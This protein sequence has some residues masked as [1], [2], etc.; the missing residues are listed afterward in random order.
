MSH[1]GEYRVPPV[2]VGPSQKRIVGISG[3]QG[4]PHGNSS[5]YTAMSAP[6]DGDTHM[7]ISEPNSRPVA[8]YIYPAGSQGVRL[9]NRTTPL[10]HHLDA[11]EQRMTQHI[12][13]LE[14]KIGELA[15]A[16][17]S[18]RQPLQDFCAEE[19]NNIDPRLSMLPNDSSQLREPVM[20]HDPVVAQQLEFLERENAELRFAL[21][22]HNARVASEFAPNLQ[23]GSS[24]YPGHDLTALADAALASTP[25]G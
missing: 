1:N 24:A 18:Q 11:M 4:S 17:I 22:C 16:F 10:K 14:Q 7:A 19:S 12:S 15:T 20:S 25:D 6:A 21:Q 13:S 2:P 3:A 23:H 9:N 5:T 8:T